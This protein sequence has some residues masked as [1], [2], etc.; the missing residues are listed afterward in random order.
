MVQSFSQAHID[1]I[2]LKIATYGNIP[3][4]KITIIIIIIL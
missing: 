3:Q 4:L 1:S 2:L